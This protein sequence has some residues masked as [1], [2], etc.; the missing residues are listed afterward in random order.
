MKKF[1]E[2]LNSIDDRS[3]DLIITGVEY[4]YN[5]NRIVIKAQYTCD[6]FLDDVRKKLENAIYEYF[7]KKIA[8][9]LKLKKYI[10]DTDVIKSYVMSY[11]SANFASVLQSDNTFAV[12]V[13]LREEDG[14]YVIVIKTNAENDAHLRQSG[15]E[16]SILEYLRRVTKEDYDIKMLVVDSDSEYDADILQQRYS[17][18][19]NNNFEHIEYNPIEISSIHNLVG[20]IDVDFV[21]PIATFTTEQKSAVIVG[22]VSYYRVSEYES[23]F[24]NK[25]GTSK[26]AKRVNFVLKDGSDKMNCVYFPNNADVEKIEELSDGEKIVVKGDI[27]DNEDRGLSF[28]VKAIALCAFE[29]FVKPERV[30]EAKTVNDK[31]YY[32]S[33]KPYVSANQSDL[34]VKEEKID[35]FL[36]NNDVVVFDLETTG[37]NVAECQIIEIG[38]VKMRQGRIVETFETLVK[39]IGHIPDDATAV[40]NITDEMVA[41]CYN[42]DQIFPDFYKFIDGCVLVAYNI[43]YDC[44]VLQAYG[45]KNGFAINNKQVD[46]LKLAKKALPEYKSHKLGKVVK[47]L[48]ITLDNAHRAIF[49]TIAT[50]EVL[51]VTLNMLSEEDKKQIL[52]E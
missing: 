12:D 47:I 41:E 28:K 40:N 45:D 50:A 25:D 43:A 44:G 48:N 52:G 33:P 10:I 49:D 37:L 29:P 3:K 9:E 4:D 22:E 5:S 8:V 38:A 23:R 6:T 30:V 24:K 16:D 31:Y 14:V 34:F 42:I 19:N 1:L 20:E 11:V 13:N 7:D 35:E 46:A 27:V 26:T 32:V 51:K 18:L 21:Y 17:L 39:P 2:Y 36:L 15:F